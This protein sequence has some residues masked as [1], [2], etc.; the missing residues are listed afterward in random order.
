LKNWA[1]FSLSLIDESVD[2]ALDGLVADRPGRELQIFGCVL[3]HE[4]L[5]ALPESSGAAASPFQ[6]VGLAEDFFRAGRF[7]VPVL[8]LLAM[9]LPAYVQAVGTSKQADAQLSGAGWAKP[10]GRW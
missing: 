2:H 1:N 10:S 4:V 5:E 9:L 8:D 3:V 7:L 6:A